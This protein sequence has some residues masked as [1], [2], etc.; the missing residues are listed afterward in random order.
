MRI[1]V[2]TQQ[3]SGVGYHRLMMPIYYMAKDYAY[4]TDTINDEILSEGFDLVVVNRFIPTCHITNLIAYREKYGFKLIVD[5]DDYW[6]LDPW[7]ILYG[8]YEAQP[9]IE[10]IMAA[11]M[12]TCTNMTLRYHISQINSKV[13]V[14]PNALPFGKDQFTDVK[15]KSDKT[16]VLYAGSIT[17]EKDIALLRNPFKKILSDKRLVN[18]MQF[19]MCGYDPANEFS[20]SVWGRMIN[21]YT[22]G[23]KMPGYIKPALP[24]DK[25]M[26]FY[27][28][29]D[30][31]IVPLVESKF[32]SMKSNLKVLEAATKKIPVIVS[33]V[34]PYKNCP[35][36]IKSD[37]QTDWYKNLKKLANDAIYRKEMGEANYEWCADNF[38]LDKINKLREQ[39]YRSLI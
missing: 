28:E 12:V 19:I 23:L 33:N 7:H 26:N 9:I 11:D 13:H 22:V 32:N 39:L 21:D 30:I 17:H 25:Y 10:H 6:H 27:C 34:D 18:D 3:N 4:F 1:L 36:V 29:A 5:V 14:V 37:K 16:R 15:H 8:Q 2:I 38:H 20:A 31:A 24:I 35:Y